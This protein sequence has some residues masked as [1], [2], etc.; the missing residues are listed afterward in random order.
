MPFGLSNAPLTFQRFMNELFA[1]LLD[2]CVIVYLNDILIYSK[3]LKEYKKQVKEVLR[4]LKA[5]RLYAS[6]SKYEF[7]QEQ[8]K[9]LEFILSPKGLWMVRRYASFRNGPPT[10]IEECTILFGV[11]KFLQKIYKQLL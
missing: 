10:S 11:C 8:V 5:N 3:N 7:H 9:F 1:D 4:H 6:P 2:I